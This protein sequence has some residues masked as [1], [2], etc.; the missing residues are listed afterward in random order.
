MFGSPQKIFPPPPPSV[1]PIN[2]ISRLARFLNTGRLRFF[3]LLV[4]LIIVASSGHR[5]F[6]ACDVLPQRFKVGDRVRIN[7]DYLGYDSSD[8]YPLYSTPRTSAN[9]PSHSFRVK[10]NSIVIITGGPVET[11]FT[12][13]V[14]HLPEEHYN[15]RYW[16]V[17]GTESSSGAEVSGWVTGAVALDYSNKCIRGYSLRRLSSTFSDNDSDDSPQDDQ[18]PEEAEPEEPPVSDHVEDVESEI[19]S[20]G[21]CVSMPYGLE[22]IGIKKIDVNNCAVLGNDAACNMNLLDGVT[23]DG[24]VEQG[25]KFCFP[26]R[27]AVYYIPNQLAGGVPVGRGF[28][29]QPL[30]Y[31]HSSN[32]TWINRVPGTGKLLLAA[33]GHPPSGDDDRNIVKPQC[34]TLDAKLRPGQRAKNAIRS[35]IKIRDAAD[36]SG[37][38]LGKL[39]A[40]MV[41]DVLEGP[42]RSDGYQWFKIRH[43]TITGWAAESG[44]CKY[45]LQQTSE[46]VSQP[47]TRRSG[48]PI[49]VDGRCELEDAIEA[50]NRDRVVGGCP[51][52]R[53]GDAIRLDTSVTLKRKL[54]A[55]ESTIVI[56]GNNH[57]ISGENRYQIFEVAGGA[58]LTLRDLTLRNG[59]TDRQGG[60]LVNNG[61]VAIT[62]STIRNNAADKDG[63]AISNSGTLTVNNSAFRNNTA[64]ESGGAIRNK[65]SLTASN[66]RFIG[67]RGEAGGA[68]DHDGDSIRLSGN[69]FSNNSP[70]NCRGEGVDCGD[71][72]GLDPDELSIEIGG[73]LTGELEEGEEYH[74]IQLRLLDS[75]TISVRMTATSG[76][77][78]PGL[79]LWDND[80]TKLEDDENDNG[81]NIAEMEDIELEPGLYWIDAWSVRGGGRYELEVSGDGLP[82]VEAQVVEQPREMVYGAQTG[83]ELKGWAD[84][85]LYHFR[86]EEGDRIR[87]FMEALSAGSR[88]GGLAP[89]IKLYDDSGNELAAEQVVR[90][91]WTAKLLDFPLPKVGEYT[92]SA[93]STAP[94][95]GTYRLSLWK[96]N[97]DQLDEFNSEAYK[98][99]LPLMHTT[100][101]LIEGL[102]NVTDFLIAA[103]DAVTTGGVSLKTNAAKH[104]I[105]ETAK[106]A[107]KKLIIEG[108]R[109]STDELSDEDRVVEAVREYV[110]LAFETADGLTSGP[111]GLV[112]ELSKKSETWEEVKKNL[113][114]IIDW[115]M[116]G[117]VSDDGGICT[118]KTKHSIPVRDWPSADGEELAYLD[119]SDG[120]HPIAKVQLDDEESYYM[121]ITA[122]DCG[123]PIFKRE[124]S[125]LCT[126]GQLSFGNAAIQ[127][128]GEVFVRA[129]HVD[130]VVDGVKAASS[131]CSDL[132]DG[133]A[134]IK[135]TVRPGH[136]TAPLLVDV[137]LTEVSDSED[138]RIHV[139]G[140][141][142]LWPTWDTSGAKPREGQA[143][144]NFFD[145]WV[146]SL[147]GSEAPEEYIEYEVSV[148]RNPRF[149]KKREARVYVQNVKDDNSKGWLWD[150]SMMDFSLLDPGTWNIESLINEFGIKPGDNFSEC[151]LRDQIQGAGIFQNPDPDSSAEDQP[152]ESDDATT[153]RPSETYAIEIGGSLTG[154]LE[155]GRD[156]H[157]IRLRLNASATI[158][159]RM[160]A[161]SG[162]LAPSLKLWD[163]DGARRAQDENKQGANIAEMENLELAPGLYWID[164]LSVS[165][166]G[167]Y[168]L[169]VLDVSPPA[170]DQPDEPDDPTTD[171][172]SDRPDSDPD[173]SAVDEPDEP[174]DPA[175]D[176]PSDRPDSD[177]D[178]SAVDEPDEPDDPASDPP[179]VPPLDPYK[180]S[181]GIGDIQVGNLPAGNDY[182]EYQLR[183]LSD[184]TVTIRMSGC[185]RPGLSLHR[186]DGNKA[187]K[188]QQSRGGSNTAE[189]TNVDL[190]PGLYTISA[191]TVSGGGNY[192]LEVFSES[193]AKTSFAAPDAD[194]PIIGFGSRHKDSL[195]EGRDYDTIQ[196]CLLSPANGISIRMSTNSGDLVPGLTLYDNVDNPEDRAESQSGVA[197]LT[198]IN[199]APGVY[200]ISAW[201]V[202]GGGD[203]TLAVN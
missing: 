176:E 189:F 182:D 87:I 67:N 44:N 183:L 71:V 88:G 69:T 125:G 55:I 196:L 31:Y 144:A 97:F 99:N 123:S 154:E 18:E 46:S 168:E 63:G 198:N 57:F 136:S 108:A 126:G 79:K 170:E 102:G 104:I 53:S 6:A 90:T 160:T 84:Y 109:W 81:L 17:L 114:T 138:C 33:S 14:G 162:N 3:L 42:V 92:I 20:G 85:H 65:G 166:G 101:Q 28:Q 112:Y 75:A 151:R 164:A 155:E 103:C 202:S 74:S 62:N 200:H 27:G 2:N 119:A 191:W 178:R 134:S 66:N 150:A 16:K 127:T 173:M 175:T 8:T 40:G 133:T 77:L 143:G 135:N 186:D 59:K 188:D 4:T 157:S 70:D 121:L 132:K 100:D 13:K 49:V 32:K 51:G 68:I 111:C 52:G 64:G 140:R 96:L 201:S 116:E 95:E 142:H 105:K 9:F 89:V 45:W 34:K 91:T 26:R 37:R 148:F 159:V 12:R 60:A 54:P 38:E 185:M 73:S 117:G 23:I 174:D 181:I 122:F 15:N 110:I 115:L 93:N 179:S 35:R 124:I 48:E 158:S 11:S 118:I 171:E 1:I 78:V 25:I 30:P 94:G 50:A 156:F 167:R 113:Q 146:S 153:D 47:T 187:V 83:G 147:L 184:A 39:D 43:G 107:L 86:G 145:E 5:A 22:T 120:V 199:L 141:H 80:A 24:Y 106:Y 76:N 195:P 10:H 163:N 152:D 161:V 128:A 203:Y 180:P 41:V 169:E 192:K 72:P 165:G 56:R 61:T 137:G 36:L 21:Y 82:D 7:S 197:E 149:D 193:R 29:P 139:Y 194:K 98:K 190:G 129:K 172:P 58:V 19:V 177:P 131:S 130:S